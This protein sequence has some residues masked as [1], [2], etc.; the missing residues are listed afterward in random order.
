MISLPSGERYALNVWTYKI[1][2]R[3]VTRD[4]E[5]DEPLGGK[6]L[7]PPDLFVER[8]ERELLEEVVRHLI[9][10]RQLRPEWLVRSCC[11]EG[12]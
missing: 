5:R 10:M 1:L 7:L 6:N 11:A 3:I 2:P 12:A 4:R 9:Q 8:L